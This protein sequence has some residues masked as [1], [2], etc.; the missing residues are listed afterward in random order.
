MLA[1]NMV[2]V[3]IAAGVGSVILRPRFMNAPTWRATITPLASI[4]GSG[5]LIVGPILAH[6]VGNWAWFAMTGLCAVAYLFGFAIRR[7]ILFVEPLL[8]KGPPPAIAILEKA[9]DLA[10]AF[11]YFVS[12][13]YYLNLFASFALR[14]VGIVDVE[15]TRALS[16]AV[17]VSI[18]GFG[19][20][21]GLRGLETIEEIAVGAKLSLIAGVVSAMALS[22]ILGITHGD[23]ILAD[24]LHETGP[25]KFQVLLGLIILVQGFETSRYLGASYSREMRV[26]TMRYAQWLSSAIYIVFIV[27]LTPFFRGTLPS[28]GGETAIIDMLVPIGILVAPMIIIAATASQLSAAVADMNGAGG[29]LAGATARR[30]S[31]HVGYIITAAAALFLTW[32]AHIYEI[33]VYASKAFV[34]YYGLQCILAAIVAMQ[35]GHQHSRLAALLSVLGI[36]IAALVLI[37]GIP[38]EA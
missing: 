28:T 36:S 8:R 17:I 4:I 10:L 26:R 38:V 24:V 31:V 12:V 11:A 20:Y 23:T 33:I 27:L 1:H 2:M 22:A 3:A 29:M 21:R 18:A 5:F 32:I 9:S 6:T 7:N 30:I 35:P 14:G 37:F 25:H 15:F 19:F 34:I 16:S 13:A